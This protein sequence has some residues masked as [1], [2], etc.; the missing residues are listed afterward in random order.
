MGN[1][2]NKF[3]LVVLSAGNFTGH[4]GQG[5]S[6]ITDLILAVHLEFI[7]QVARRILFR[8]L[9]NFTQGKINHLRKKD[10]DDKGQQEKD[11]QN[12]IGNAEQAFT[13]GA[14]GRHSRVYDNISP[15]LEIRSNGGVD[16]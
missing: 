12:N 13:G 8:G 16:A 9:G 7:M 11:Y 10:E 4:I 14:Q 15:Y 1:I 3:L 5:R 2:G 6:E